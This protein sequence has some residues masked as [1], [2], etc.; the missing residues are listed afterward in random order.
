MLAGYQCGTVYK[1]IFLEAEAASALA[2]YL[3][4]GVT[5]PK[6]L[7]AGSTTDPNTGT[8]VAFGPS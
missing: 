2:L 6:S 7:A 8:K 5:P 4:A 3:R 1:P